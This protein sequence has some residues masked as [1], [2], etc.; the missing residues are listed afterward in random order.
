MQKR[1][2]WLDFIKVFG[3]LATLFL[4]SNSTLVNFQVSAVSYPVELNMDYWHIGVIFASLTG[5]SFA[6][7]FM[8]LGGVALSL[9]YTSGLFF[10]KK[11]KHLFITL[12]FW[13]A[14]SLLF[15]KYIMRQDITT[16]QITELF[17]IIN[18][19]TVNL[20]ILYMLICIFLLL[21]IL[22][23]LIDYL[24]KKQLYILILLWFLSTMFIPFAPTYLNIDLM[25]FFRMI[26]GYLGYTLIGYVLSNS[27]MTKKLLWVGILFFVVGN[28]WTILG[29]INNSP[30]S[31]V[32]QGIYANQYFNRFSLPMM[33][34]T[35]G[36]FILLK[37]VAEYLMQIPF[38]YKSI[39]SISHFALGMCMVYPYWLVVLG[40]EKTGIELTAFI[41][42]PLWGVPLTASMVIIG[43]LTTVYMITKIPYLN[44]FAPKL[45]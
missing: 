11:I 14:V 43:S 13:T 28:L 18:P 2:E 27:R 41:G 38:F 35:I 5:P 31:N 30:A 34:N 12:L 6:L 17:S 3:V 7:I 1:A 44:Y 29:V 9:A 36:S 19:T 45:I 8:Y 10:I 20:W 37:H 22:K 23:F 40:T 25:I 42:N 15:Q 16:N 4:H 39:N 26:I 24:S 32:M 21:P 33:L